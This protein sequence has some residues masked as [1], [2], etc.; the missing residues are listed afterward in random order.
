MRGKL[1]NSKMAGAFAVLLA[2]FMAA[3]A[4]GETLTGTGGTEPRTR[5]Y[6]GEHREGNSWY[7]DWDDDEGEGS[8]L[9]EGGQAFLDR[10]LA[11]NGAYRDWNGWQYVTDELFA[12]CDGY[13][14]KDFPD[15]SFYLAGPY[16]RVYD[17]ESGA[18]LTL[19]E[20]FYSGFDFYDY[21]NTYLT[22]LPESTSINGSFTSDPPC[23][24]YVKRP[25][26]LAL[27]GST[28][29]TILPDFDG[30]A[31]V[32]IVLPSEFYDV[33]EDEDEGKI[34][35]TMEYL[36]FVPLMH[37]ISPWGGCTVDVRYQETVSPS[38]MKLRKPALRIDGGTALAAEEKINASLDGMLPEVLGTLD[39]V[40]PGLQYLYDDPDASPG[41]IQPFA[42][43]RD[44]YV[45]VS[46]H[47]MYFDYEIGSYDR[48]AL[49]AGAAFDLHT[50][51][52]V[53]DTADLAGL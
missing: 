11:E 19:P 22:L 34:Y 24:G 49:L 27:D 23:Y 1:L 26:T 33:Y 41:W 9:D 17:V 44:H 21:V 43:V 47:L 3:G 28:P 7:D 18:V 46:Y 51:E 13:Q 12:V 8:V 38:G 31:Y 32:Q 52:K 10:W 36:L 5:Y 42:R 30:Q 53:A 29:F 15:D 50:G 6:S 16:T 4:A 14:D 2:L 20:V 40:L 25:F 37:D 48:V 35:R 45:A 39:A